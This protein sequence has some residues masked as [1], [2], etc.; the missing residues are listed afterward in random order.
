MW[1]PQT[2]R[3]VIAKEMPNPNAVK[4]RSTTSMDFSEVYGISVGPF[5]LSHCLDNGG[6]HKP[7]FPRKELLENVEN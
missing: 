2:I 6:P 4:R 3:I 5:G 1:L 7:V